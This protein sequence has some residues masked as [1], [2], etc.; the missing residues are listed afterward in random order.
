[1]HTPKSVRDNVT[2]RI[3]CDFEIQIDP[4]QIP[5]GRPD[6]ELIKKKRTCHF[7]DFAVPAD[8]GVK[9]KEGE[10]IAKTLDLIKELKVLP[11]PL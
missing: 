3:I 10:K 6:L 7:V 1:M 11:N 2:Y 9:I 5:V 4:Q 8:L